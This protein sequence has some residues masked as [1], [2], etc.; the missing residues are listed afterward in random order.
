M[1]TCHNNTD[2]FLNSTSDY[3]LHI[4]KVSIGRLC[5]LLARHYIS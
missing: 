5:L 3:K 1:Y 2:V 4:E